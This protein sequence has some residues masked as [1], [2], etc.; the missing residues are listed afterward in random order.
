MKLSWCFFFK[1]YCMYRL[2]KLKVRR[3]S[4]VEYF[5][6][7]NNLFRQFTV[8]NAC[9]SLNYLFFTHGKHYGNKYDL[10]TVSRFLFLS[11]KQMCTHTH[12]Y[13][14]TEIYLSI[15]IYLQNKCFEMALKQSNG[16]SSS[17][18]LKAT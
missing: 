1:F 12:I 9:V 10:V 3:K 13:I 18:C 5:I 15:S 14:P 8:N 4:L 2:N 16:A 11:S 17:S 7:F 6:R